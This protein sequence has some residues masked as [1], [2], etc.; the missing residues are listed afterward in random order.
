[1]IKKYFLLSIHDIKLLSVEK[2]FPTEKNNSVNAIPTIL[3]NWV[4]PTVIV[5]WDVCLNIILKQS[6]GKKALI[7]I[8]FFV[9]FQRPTGCG[10]SLKSAFLPVRIK[11]LNQIGV[12]FSLFLCSLFQHKH[13]CASLR[14]RFLMLDLIYS[15]TLSLCFLRTVRIRKLSY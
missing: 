1:M 12:W 9:I 13:L 10:R 15:I 14:N 6:L 5:L 8:T 4:S 2:N 11:I 3:I 7:L